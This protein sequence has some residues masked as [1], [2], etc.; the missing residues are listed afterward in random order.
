M[1]HNIIQGNLERCF[2]GTLNVLL[3]PRG[4][5]LARR[6]S[7]TPPAVEYI[8]RSPLQRCRRTAELL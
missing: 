5:E 1:H 3:L 4:E 6:V 7:V 8:Y 2:I